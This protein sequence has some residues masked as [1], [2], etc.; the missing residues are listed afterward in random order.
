MPVVAERLKSGDAVLLTYQDTAGT[1]KI[2]YPVLQILTTLGFAELQR[3]GIDLDASAL[4]SL[5][6]IIRHVEPGVGTLLREKN[7][8]VYMSRQSLPV[9]VSLPVLFG[10]ATFFGFSMQP[11][12]P[13]ANVGVPAQ[14]VLDSR[15][16]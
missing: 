8:L 14:P 16:P 3:E 1:M 9:N 2:I 10:D 4:P 12:Q 5:A 11:A 7:G 13:P 6:S 15:G